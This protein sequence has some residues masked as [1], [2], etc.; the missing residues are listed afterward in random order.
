MIITII[1][2]YGVHDVV[3]YIVL[4]SSRTYSISTVPVDIIL[5]FVSTQYVLGT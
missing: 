1:G 5:Y 2:I 3:L 4:F